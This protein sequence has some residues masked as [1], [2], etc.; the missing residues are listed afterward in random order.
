MKKGDQIYTPRF[1]TVTIEKV[2]KSEE[3][4]R[5]E[6]YAEP[7]HYDDPNYSILGKHTGTNRMTFAACRK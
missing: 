4:A 5:K 7:T 3:N 2:F 6:K 1:C